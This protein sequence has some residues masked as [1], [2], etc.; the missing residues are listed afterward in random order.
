VVERVLQEGLN[1]VLWCVVGTCGGAFLALR[2]GKVPTAIQ[3][4][5]AGFIIEQSLINGAEL[6]DVQGTVI[7]SNQRFASGMLKDGELAQGGEKGGV[8]ERAVLQAAK[9]PGTKQIPA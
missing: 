8:V 6:F 5:G 2:K 7:D 4:S 1:Q 3:L 9:S